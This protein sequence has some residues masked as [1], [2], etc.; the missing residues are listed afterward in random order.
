MSRR[1][2]VLL[3]IAFLWLGSTCLAIAFFPETILASWPMRAPLVFPFALV[4]GWLGLLGILRGR[5]WHPHAAETD[6]VMNDEF[7]HSNMLRA[8]RAGFAAVLLLQV[9]L[10]LALVHVQTW[11]ALV[12]MAGTTITLGM[13]VTIAV[14]LYLDRE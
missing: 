9:P 3:L 14:F 12:A 7:R 13:S 11:R 10:A 6:V 4:V 8:Q 5:R 2:F 1:A